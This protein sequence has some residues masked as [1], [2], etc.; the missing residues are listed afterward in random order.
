MHLHVPDNFLD[1]LVLHLPSE[2]VEEGKLVI[3]II[4]VV[5]SCP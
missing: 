1:A 5:R 4:A 3:A 2:L